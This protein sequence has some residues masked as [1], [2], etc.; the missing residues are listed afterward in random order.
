MLGLEGRGEEAMAG[1]TL[2]GA[3]EVGA[4]ELRSGGSCR[5]RERAEEERVGCAVV[6]GLWCSGGGRE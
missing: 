2:V 4:E 5:G 1:A 3:A 6:E